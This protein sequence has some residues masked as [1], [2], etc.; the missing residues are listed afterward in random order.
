VNDQ[1]AM[2]LLLTGHGQKFVFPEALRY[3]TASEF[4]LRWTTLD[5]RVWPNGDAM[6]DSGTALAPKMAHANMRPLKRKKKDL[7][8]HQ[9][10]FLN[11]DADGC[12]IVSNSPQ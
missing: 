6:F 10:W 3:R 4:G 9:L 7:A 12:E 8:K 5:D 2:Q 11:D 1:D